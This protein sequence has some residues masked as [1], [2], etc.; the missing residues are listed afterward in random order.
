MSIAINISQVE[1]LSGKR[2][3]SVDE[4]LNA[5]DESCPASG[6]LELESFEK[7]QKLADTL[8]M[9]VSELLADTRKDLD[10]GVVI[11]RSDEGFAKEVSRKGSRYYTYQHLA[12]SN[13][14]PELMALKVLLHC[15]DNDGVALNRGHASREVI[16]AL[17]G[18]VRF[19]WR[20]EGAEDVK[21]ATL[22]PGDSVYISP[23]V[24]HSFI[25]LESGA[26]ILAFNYELT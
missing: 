2:K 23:G 8:I 3:M 9:P 26:E 6:V 1:M 17:K 21:S 15:E 18:S 10:G 5:I 4:V 24:K 11:S 13:T 12:T 7:V 22:N 16:Y 14:A 20:D 25:A 19:D